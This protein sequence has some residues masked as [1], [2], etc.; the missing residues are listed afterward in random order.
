MDCSTDV[1]LNSSGIPLNSTLM[2]SRS[3]SVIQNYGDNI[4]Y[5]Y[6]MHVKNIAKFNLLNIQARYMHNISYNVS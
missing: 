5:G 1:K 2:Y 6:K 4:L 3:F